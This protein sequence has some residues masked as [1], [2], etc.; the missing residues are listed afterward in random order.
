MTGASSLN[1]LPERLYAEFLRLGAD[2]QVAREVADL[3]KRRDVREEVA[4]KAI[5]RL[6]AT[7]PPKET[8]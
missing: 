8:E 1:D 4:L 2:A 3:W 6:T 5:A 7:L